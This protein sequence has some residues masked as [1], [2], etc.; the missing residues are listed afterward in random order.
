LQPSSL[1]SYRESHSTCFPRH[2]DDEPSAASSNKRYPPDGSSH[3]LF[4]PSSPSKGSSFESIPQLNHHSPTNS[5]SKTGITS[6][7]SFIIKRGHINAGLYSGHHVIKDSPV[8]MLMKP[9]MLTPA[10]DYCN[11]SSLSPVSS[12]NSGHM[13]PGKV[14]DLPSGLYWEYTYKPYFICISIYSRFG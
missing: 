13:P 1:Y 14:T 12:R 5:H 3:P 4:L 2:P 6:S 11:R 7:K 9:Q 10:R 8:H